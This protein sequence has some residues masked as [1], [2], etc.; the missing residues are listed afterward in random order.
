MY[1]CTTQL[2]LSEECND[3]FSILKG[4]LVSSLI[5]GYPAFSEPFIIETGGSFK[6]LGAVLSQKIEGKERVVAYTSEG[7]KR[8]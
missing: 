5:L 8:G 4:K 1:A 3:A 7:F 2:N 6:G